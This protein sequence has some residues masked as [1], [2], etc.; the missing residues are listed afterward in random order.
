MKRFLDEAI[1][2]IH[3]DTPPPPPWRQSGVRALPIMRFETSRHSA[4]TS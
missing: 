1:R 3:L 4:V 2:P